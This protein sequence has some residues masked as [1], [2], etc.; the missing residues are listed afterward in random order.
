MQE[1]LTKRESMLADITVEREVRL[2][3]A[4]AKQLLEGNRDF[5]ELQCKE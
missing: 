3:R 5:V 2:E 4:R 1:V